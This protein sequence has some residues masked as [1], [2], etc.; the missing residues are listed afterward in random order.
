MQNVNRKWHAVYT[1]P[2]Y[3]KK[4]VSQLARKR[5]TG[6][7]PVNIVPKHLNDKNQAVSEPLFTSVVFVYV[8]VLE[9]LEVSRTHG[10]VNFMYWLNKPAVICDDEIDEIKKILAGFSI[11]QLRK[12]RVNTKEYMEVVSDSLKI[13]A[14][15]VMEV[16]A[17]RLKVTLP[18]LGYILEAEAKRN[19][20]EIINH[21]TMSQLYTRIKHRLLS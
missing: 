19:S 4:V 21:L 5:I 12:T 3:E 7:C 14:G 11:I 13:Q 20:G 1:R 8:N 6:Y 9:Q 17:D 10:V 18:S 15:N 2:N 16:S